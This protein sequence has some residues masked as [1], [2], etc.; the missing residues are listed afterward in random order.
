MVRHVCRFGAT[1]LYG[2]EERVVEL[3]DYAWRPDLFV[4]SYTKPRKETRERNGHGIFMPKSSLVFELDT[5]PP[6]GG[7]GVWL[8]TFLKIV[9][10]NSYYPQR[11]RIF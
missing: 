4:Y 5:G 3:T 7:D 6:C 11:D 9:L 10:K 1:F 2:T 8:D